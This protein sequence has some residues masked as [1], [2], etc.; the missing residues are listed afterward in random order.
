M[1]EILTLGIE[2]S[3]DETSAAVIANGR[4][5]LSDVISTSLELHK[6]YG[7]VVPEIASRKHIEYIIPVIKQALD[8][9]FDNERKNTSQ[10]QTSIIRDLA[11]AGSAENS[12]LGNLK[13]NNDYNIRQIQHSIIDDLNAVYSFD[14][15]DEP[16]TQDTT[17]PDKKMAINKKLSA[18]LLDASLPSEIII[19]VKQAILK[20]QTI[21]E[22]Q[23]LTTFDA[24]TVGNISKKIDAY[25][26]EQ[27]QKQAELEEKIV[28]LSHEIRLLKNDKNYQEKMIRQKLRYIRNNEIVYIFDA[29]N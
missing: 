18:L 10:I 17:L 20:L 27:E 2:S 21:T 12:E 29:Q 6:A 5:V 15:T 4:R 13:H 16:E 14:D 24:I 23:N 1:K 25:K 8:E 11:D 19:D 7:G 9:A 22:M 26:R 3:C 28:Q